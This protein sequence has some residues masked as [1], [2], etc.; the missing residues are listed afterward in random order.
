MTLTPEAVIG[1][2]VAFG[3]AQLVVL[4]GLK[5]IGII[6]FNSHSK[7][8]DHETFCK[9]FKEVRDEHLLQKQTI[10]RHEKELEDGKED[11]AEIKDDISK[12]NTGIA[13]IMQKLDIKLIKM[14]DKTK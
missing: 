10:A 13:L 2:I 12:I 1:M 14:W 11:F 4:M 5:K 6:N 8:S 9:S 7:C 3:L